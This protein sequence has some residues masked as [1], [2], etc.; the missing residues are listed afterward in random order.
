MFLE[1]KSSF[2]VI[3]GQ[4]VELQSMLPDDLYTPIG[5]GPIN[6]QVFDVRVIL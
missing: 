1:S 2:L 3:Q 5:G 6:D 4:A